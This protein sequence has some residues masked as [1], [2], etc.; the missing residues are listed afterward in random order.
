M[1]TPIALNA[2][3]GNYFWIWAIVCASFVP[4]TYFFG[5][6]TS[7]RTLE[8]IDTAFIERPRILMGLDPETTRVIRATKQDEENRY[9]AFAKLDS[10]KVSIDEVE[11]KSD[12]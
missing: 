4:L 12:W 10:D 7:G 6:E 3:G 9:K 1:I 8:E 2:I 11:E 5:V